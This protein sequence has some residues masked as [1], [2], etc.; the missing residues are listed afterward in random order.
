MRVIR[1][2]RTCKH[3]GVL[4]I[5]VPAVLSMSPQI[6]E[7]GHSWTADSDSFYGDSGVLP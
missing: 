1:C 5:E 2:L 3:L 4:Q 7:W 6:S